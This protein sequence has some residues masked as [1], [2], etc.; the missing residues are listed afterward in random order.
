MAR[1]LLCVVVAPR[2]NWQL[3]AL[4]RQTPLANPT[5][6]Q[7]SGRRLLGAGAQLGIDRW[8]PVA[9]HVVI[10]SVVVTSSSRRPT[11]IFTKTLKNLHLSRPAGAL[12]CISC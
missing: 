3:G 6:V 10:S 7:F 11:F 5:S 8:P 9:A 2:S 4:H 12:A 1:A